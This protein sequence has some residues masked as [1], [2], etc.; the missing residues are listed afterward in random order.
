MNQKSFNPEMLILARE[1]KGWSQAEVAGSV[2]VMQGTISKIECGLLVPSPELV[3]TFADKLEFPDQFFFETDRVF[4]FN[5]TVFFHRKRQSV[6]DRTLRK[7]HAQMNLS[8]MRV[9]KLRLS[10][11]LQSKVRFQPMDPREY[12]GGVPA[13][14]RLVRQM[15]LLPP[16]PIRN[17]VEA[18]EDAGGIVI[19]YD[20]GTKQ[21]DAISE[22][23]D[24]SPPIFLVNTNDEIPW[25]RRRLTL[26]HELGHV[27]MH[28]VP[29]L[30]SPQI[31]DEATEFAAEFL[32]PRKEIKPSLY[33]LTMAKLADLKRYWRVSM[34]ALIERARQLKTITEYQRRLFYMRLNSNGHTR[35]HEPL[36][37]EY[38]PERPE[39]Y[40]RMVKT[41]L[42]DLGYS[43]KE[44]AT[45]LFFGKEQSFVD[46]FLNT[47]CLR[48]V[49]A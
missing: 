30:P 1:S 49:V 37:R 21:A 5:S 29:N 41:H 10:L 33:S 2:A 15:W 22:W 12:A 13:V 6:P 39:L 47:D 16:G 18:I 26:A 27:I 20:F 45:I 3:N 31:E 9:R 4:G 35:L 46:E 11:S 25:D 38:A 36:E 24:D 8:R 17:L 7:L 28:A 23:I 48:L 32:M 44:I 19:D 40:R 42:H 43:V 34:Q 14:A